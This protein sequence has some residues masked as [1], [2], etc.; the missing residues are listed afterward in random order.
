MSPQNAPSSQRASTGQV[1]RRSSA[2]PNP[3][4]D[5][6]RFFE[7]FFPPDLF[8]FG[9]GW[10]QWAARSEG[11]LP[12]VDVIDRGEDIVVR[13]EVPGVKREDLDVSVS[14]NIV[15]IHGVSRQEEQ[16]KEERYYRREMSRAEYMRSVSL[17]ADVKGEEAKAR[18]EDGV[19]ELTLP[20]Q[21]PAPRRSI[22][23]E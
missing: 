15:T 17:P 16:R 1:Q 10:P 4:E 23:I 9:R 13:A 14:D 19:L 22:K 5:M 11:R 7:N 20:K 18:F 12:A 2:P 3:W 6:D 8:R 21:S